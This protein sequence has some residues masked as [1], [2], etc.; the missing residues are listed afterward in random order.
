MSKY[1]L[2]ARKAKER[3]RVEKRSISPNVRLDDSGD[4]V[5]EVMLG[6]E[7]VRVHERGDEKNN[8]DIDIVEDADSD[9][10]RITFRL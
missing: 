8:N 10:K 9:L 7:R 3:K 1:R 2:K 6:L 4:G 5:A